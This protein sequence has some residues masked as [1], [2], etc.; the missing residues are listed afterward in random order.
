MS[1]GH[2]RCVRITKARSWVRRDTGDVIFSKGGDR[3]SVVDDSLESPNAVIRP[4]C[5]ARPWAMLLI[6]LVVGIYVFATFALTVEA[7]EDAVLPGDT[8]VARRLQNVSIP[9][10]QAMVDALNWCGQAGP[11]VVLAVAVG[12]GLLVTR[13]YAEIVLM[14]SAVGVHLV[15]Q[16]LKH[17]VA[18]PRPTPDLVRVSGHESGFGY[19]SG[20]AMATVVYGGIITYLAWWCVRPR[21]L[22]LTI[23]AAAVL[24]MLGIGF[25]RVYVGAHWP[26][27]VLG[28]YLWGILYVVVVV[29]IFHRRLPVVESRDR[30]EWTQSADRDREHA[31]PDPCDG[32]LQVCGPDARLRRRTDGSSTGPGGIDAQPRGE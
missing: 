17:L 23:Q 7:S 13:H 1:V 9:G 24:M 11:L 29:A 5:E 3:S 26:S 2:R 15:N 14:M 19:P 28:G 21:A 20:H 31:R 16:T 22:R 27:D 12:V 25:S 4:R 18:S 30:A 10:G 8:A 6:V 32:S